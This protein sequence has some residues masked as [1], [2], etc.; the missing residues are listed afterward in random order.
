MPRKKLSDEQK[1]LLENNREFI[2]N[3]PDSTERYNKATSVLKE[4]WMFASLLATFRMSAPSHVLIL[5][6]DMPLWAKYII[7]HLSDLT[8][9]AGNKLTEKMKKRLDQLTRRK[10][11]K[12]ARKEYGKAKEKDD[13]EKMKLYS[14]IL[15]GMIKEAGL[16]EA[17]CI[18]EMREISEMYN[19]LKVFGVTKAED[20]WKGIETVLYG[21]GKTIHF[22]P[23]TELSTLRAKE[24]TRGIIISLDENGHLRFSLTSRGKN[25][26]FGVLPGDRFVQDEV[27][28]LER[29]MAEEESARKKA[30]SYDRLPAE[31]RGIIQSEMEAVATYLSTGSAEGT[32]RPR[33]A[34]IV[35]EIIRGEIRIFVHVTIEGKAVEKLDRNGD[36][37]HV[38]AKA[39]RIGCDINTQT[40]AAYNGKE[41]TFENLAERGMSIWEKEAEERRILR[42]MD[43][44]RR[45]SNPQYYNENGT[46]KKEKK[47][48]KYSKNYKKLR[49]R[50]RELRRLNSRN[51]HYAID[52]AVNLLRENGAILI[53][54]KKNASAL[55]KKAKP[56]KEKEKEKDNANKKNAKRKRFGHSIQNRCPGY[57]QEKAEKVFTSTG[58]EYYEVDPVKHRAT[59]FDPL[60]GEYVKHEIWERRFGIGKDKVIIILR[61]PKSAFNL[62]WTNLETMLIDEEKA[63]A[64]AW[65]YIEADKRLQEEMIKNKRNVKNSGI[66]FRKA[67]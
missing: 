34:T 41:L 29:R 57:F 55:A 50:L 2:R 67:A 11:Y 1:K 42:A 44:S 13:K 26:S 52:E 18:K 31:K 36:K 4:Q 33:Y 63:K 38:W 47:H 51:R 62:Y 7:L 24:S 37:R 16:S 23:Y 59:Q 20:I 9:K 54:E 53:T 19:L 35:P 3:I 65:N 49:R 12:W 14:E 28:L 30:G 60:T 22:T 56:K 61:D 45:A 5:E 58:G 46:I 17:I 8:R 25:I 64:D 66:R 6:A 40:F 27:A 39:G 21:D 43:R 32:F 48:W 10:R 15:E